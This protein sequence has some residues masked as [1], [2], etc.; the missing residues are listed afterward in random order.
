MGDT[1]NQDDLVPL[2][3][4]AVS[5]AFAEKTLRAAQRTLRASLVAI[6]LSMAAAATTGLLAFGD[7]FTRLVARYVPAA[8]PSAPTFDERLDAISAELQALRQSIR[9]SEAW[10][11]QAARAFDSLAQETERLGAQQS[12]LSG[13]VETVRRSMALAYSSDSLQQILADMPQPRPRP[14]R[15]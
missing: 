4:E 2:R 3:G 7:D 14:A 5:V 12:A 11:Q 1:A 6:A 13:R 10:Q 15:D 8:A 9:D